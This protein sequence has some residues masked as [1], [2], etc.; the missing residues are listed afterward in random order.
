MVDITIKREMDDN[1]EGQ[2]LEEDANLSDANI[3]IKEEMV[4][5]EG[6]EAEGQPLEEMDEADDEGVN[7][8]LTSGH[9][10]KKPYE[11]NIC[12]LNFARKAALT[13]HVSRCAHTVEKT[14]KCDQCEMSL[15]TRSCLIAHK[16]RHACKK[17]PFKCT[18]C[19]KYYRVERQ[20]GHHMYR[21]IYNPTSC[22]K[23]SEGFN[24]YLRQKENIDQINT[25][26]NQQHYT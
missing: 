6:G 25:Y 5:E 20:L 1:M 19:G 10:D 4:K 18:D 12:K 24:A 14:Y 7:T 11:C 22:D 8:T 21:A 3:T 9:T 26:L 13:N 23:T 17:P 15:R 2:I 16:R